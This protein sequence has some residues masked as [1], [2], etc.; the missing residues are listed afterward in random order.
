MMDNKSIDK[1]IKSAERLIRDYKGSSYTFG[2]DCLN[3]T[4]TYI[5]QFG[6]D[7]LLII[8]R[9]SWAV[10]LR[11]KVYKMLDREN[12]KILES[13]DSA[14]PNN[15]VADVYEL[16]DT[17]SRLKPSSITCMGGGSAIDCAKAANAFACL[18][19]N[20][21]D[22]EMF[23]GTN[24]V[25]KIAEKKNKKLYPLIAV[26]LLAGFGS[27]LTSYSNITFPD[28]SQKK[29]IVDDIIIPD[30]T[31]FDYGSTI[32][33][34]RELTLDGAMD[35]LSHALEA[36]YGADAEKIGTDQFN[37]LEEICLTAISMIIE[38]LP[39]LADDL[40][41]IK[42]REIIGL[43]TDLGGYS[44][45]FG[46]TSGAHLN[47]YSLVDIL[48]HGRACAVLNPYYT[49]FFAPS[50]KTKLVK[51]VGIYKEY[52]EDDMDIGDITAGK[53]SSRE[54]G[55]LIAS[56]MISF[57][58]KIGFPFKLNQVERFSE[59]HLE[60]IIEAAKNPQLEMKL[61]NMPVS[62]NAELVDEYM[63]PILLAA[64]TGDFSHIKNLE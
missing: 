48:P 44:I 32:T 16:A 15:P 24:N 37:L 18:G 55:E 40:E 61:K 43:A 20:P 22:L 47:S 53:V 1:N 27:H 17:I 30:R 36:Y 6:N 59:K 31:V 58:K 50:I 2:F 57:S 12:I 19:E 41:N 45:M 11:E 4:A 34:P 64:D 39:G 51:L 8:S 63:G 46:G 49:V 23:F 33:A 42:Y 54:L 28:I 26:E 62:L 10:P 29:L 9:N 38:A 5:R 21:E 14:A 13:A 35:G 60:K 56:A 3:S 7:T 52:L 25:S